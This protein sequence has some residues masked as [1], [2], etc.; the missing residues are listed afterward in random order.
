MIGGGLYA[1]TIVGVDFNELTGDVKYCIVDPHYTGSDDLKTIVS[2]GW[3]GW[4]DSSFWDP[5]VFYNLCC[6]LKSSMY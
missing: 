3:C 6:P 1:Y 4:K 5:N 2:K